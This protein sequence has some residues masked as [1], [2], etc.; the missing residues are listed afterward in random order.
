MQRVRRIGAESRKYSI[1]VYCQTYGAR[2]EDGSVRPLD[3]K[4]VERWIRSGREVENGPDLPPLDAPAEMAEW[5][6]RVYGRKVPEVLL[7]FESAEKKGAEPEKGEPVGRDAPGDAGEDARRAFR[8]AVEA[9]DRDSLGIDAALQ[10]ARAAERLAFHQWQVVLEE[11][12]RYAESV[13]S[14][15][16]KAWE[17]AA[18]VLLRAEEKAEK[19]LAGSAEWARWEEIEAAVCEREGYLARGIRSLLTRVV[20][21][22][23][24]PPGLFAGLEKSFQEEV[25]RLFGVM[26]SGDFRELLELEG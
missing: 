11:P 12:E 22:V 8:R 24:L 6:R 25:D 19:I 17:D 16:K 1:S 9:A 21:K 23:T 26:S 18:T 15:R 7:F 20:T 13:I 5:Y 2:L 4:T 10:R 3:R 14:K